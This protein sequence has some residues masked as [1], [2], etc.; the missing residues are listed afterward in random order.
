MIPVG[1]VAEVGDPPLR[2]LVFSRA[3]FASDCERE[4]CGEHANGGNGKPPTSPTT[5]TTPDRWHV[6][7]LL[8]AAPAAG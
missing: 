4:Q 6:V 1:L 7:C 2:P 5:L 3:R 8:L